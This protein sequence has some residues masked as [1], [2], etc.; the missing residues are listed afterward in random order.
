MIKDNIVYYT[1]ENV[2]MSLRELELQPDCDRRIEY[3]FYSV[4]ISKDFDE[5][6]E[7]LRKII[8]ANFVLTEFKR[9]WRQ[10]VYTVDTPWGDRNYLKVSIR[11]CKD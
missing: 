8:S 7:T 1:E 6:T 5:L 10:I 4:N 3:I 11:E 2:P 9:T